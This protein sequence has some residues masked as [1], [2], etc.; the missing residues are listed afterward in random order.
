MKGIALI[1]IVFF[2]CFSSIS[3]IRKGRSGLGQETINPSNNFKKN[4]QDKNFIHKS[5]LLF[6]A[7]GG[8]NKGYDMIRSEN[9]IGMHER[10]MSA[11]ESSG[12][13]LSDGATAK[14]IN[15]MDAQYKQQISAADQ[16]VEKDVK[17]NN[18]EVQAKLTNATKIMEQEVVNST[19]KINQTIVAQGEEILKEVKK[20]TKKIDRHITK[21]GVEVDENM[22]QTLQ[23]KL[24]TVQDEIENKQT[25]LAN[26]EAQ[27]D[28]LSSQIPPPV[29]ICETY[30][31]CQSCTGNAA[32]GWC[33]DNKEC[34]QG[35][36]ISP[37]HGTCTFYNYGTCQGSECAGFSNCEVM[38]YKTA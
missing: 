23:L 12:Q 11:S 18:E 38:T 3:A 34:V 4:H 1:A 32:C 26:L 6:T 29:S 17:E 15:Q 35:D 9:L 33:L 7:A 14:T 37:T 25:Q 36:S 2:L 21:V 24:L 27:I 16:N 30:S 5:P 10:D 20:A 22:V 8:A 13:K 31:N 19:K 28:T